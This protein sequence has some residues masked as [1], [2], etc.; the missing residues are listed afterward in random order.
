MRKSSWVLWLWRLPRARVL[1]IALVVPLALGASASAQQVVS[2]THWRVEL[3]AW[4]PFAEVVDPLHPF[5]HSWSAAAH[6]SGP[7]PT[8]FQPPRYAFG[9]AMMAFRGDNHV[10]YHG[11]FRVLVWVKFDEIVHDNDIG[12]KP[13]EVVI[14]AQGEQYGESHLDEVFQWGH[15]SRSCELHDR[16]ATSATW[17]TR[18]GRTGATIELGIHS[19]NPFFPKKLE[20]AI[21]SRLE[22]T[23]AVG[24][25]VYG[26]DPNGPAKVVAVTNTRL[27]VALGADRFPSH[28][29]QVQADGHILAQP[30]LND[31]SCVDPIFGLAGAANVF[32]GLAFGPST[33]QAVVRALTV[34][35]GPPGPGETP[36]STEGMP[37]APNVRAPSPLCPR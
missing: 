3:K 21:D 11:G 29:V 36:V 16:T 17:V 33:S 22:L 20:P 35:A 37:L 18:L 19:G 14:T 8:C 6:P 30:V 27:A 25:R 34:I 10:S 28:G 5:M 4:I 31:A 23:A 13:P 26:S 7:Q 24:D 32:R 1:M 15:N 2:V 9:H 12:V